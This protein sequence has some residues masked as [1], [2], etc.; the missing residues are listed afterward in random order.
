MWLILVTVP[1]GFLM[2]GVARTTWPCSLKCCVHSWMG[3]S[4]KAAQL[5]QLSFRQVSSPSPPESCPAALQSWLL[6]GDL[7]DR[8]S[9]VVVDAFGCG[10]GWEG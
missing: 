7:S 5:G 6:S 1:I 9:S 3:W 8:H 10:W 4:S 2:K